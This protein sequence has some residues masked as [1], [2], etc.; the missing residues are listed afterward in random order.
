MSS[1]KVY[2]VVNQKGGVGKTTIA[3]N[4]AAVT[5]EVHPPDVPPEVA[6][7]LKEL[8]PEDPDS[9][10]ELEL[11]MEKVTAHVLAVSTDPQQSLVEWLEKVERAYW[12]QKKPLPLDY[13]QEDE[14]PRVLAS[15]KT[16]DVYRRIFVD[17]PGWLPSE[18]ARQK[19]EPTE[20]LI[21]RASLESADLAILPL[22]PEDLAFNPTKRTI[23]EVVE[24]LKIPFVVVLTNWDPRDGDGDLADTRDRAKAEGWPLANTVVRRYKLHTSAPAAGR[25]CTDYPKNRVAVEARSDF[26]K[27]GMELA[28]NGGN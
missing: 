3:A 22:E 6:A 27:L 9:E 26:L 18:H 12:K 28:L 24:P 2:V 15:L 17:S 10:A 8:D 13:S 19:D 5:A 25:L 4:L 21:V 11:L 16:A 7:A 1:T 14:N 23:E 20:K